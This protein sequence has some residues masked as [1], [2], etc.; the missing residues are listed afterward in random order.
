MTIQ[1]SRGSTVLS[2]SAVWRDSFEAPIEE[3]MRRYRDPEIRE[4]LIADGERLKP[5][6]A[7]LIVKRGRTP[8]TAA[9]EGRRVKEIAA[10]AGKTFTE[11]LLDIAVA[12]ELETEFALNGFLHGEEDKVAVLLKHPGVQIGAGDAGAHISQFAGAGDTSYLLERFVRERGD[13]KLPDAVRRLTSELA[14][15]WGFKDRGRLQA[16]GFADLVLFDP[17]TIARGEEIWLDDVPGDQ[18][19]YVRKPA[20]VERVIV[21][22]EVLVQAGDYT[23]SLPGRVL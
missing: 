12:D 14:D 20:G 15:S 3:R 22:G 6:L 7:P 11:T 21:N 8:A 2:K 19:R 9:L 16:G 4:A 23:K 1:L 10:E 13:L 18:G 17:Q 5:A